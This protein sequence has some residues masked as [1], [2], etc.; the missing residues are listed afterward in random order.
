[1]AELALNII[2]WIGIGA[3]AVLIAGVIVA[4]VGLSLTRRWRD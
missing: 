2:G 4:V 1:M 3:L